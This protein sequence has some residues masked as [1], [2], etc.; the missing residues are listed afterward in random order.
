M[1]LPATPIKVLTALAT[2]DVSSSL[3]SALR[4]TASY[5]FASRRSRAFRKPAYQ[6]TTSCAS[7]IPILTFSSF[8]ALLAVRPSTSKVSIAVL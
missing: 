7:S 3:P 2:A 6:E 5:E 8:P 1:A 4:I